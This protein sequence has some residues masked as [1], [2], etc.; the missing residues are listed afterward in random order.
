MKPISKLNFFSLLVER[1]W[2]GGASA[3]SFHSNLISFWLH[4]HY[5]NMKFK[6]SFQCL[7]LKR[8]YNSTCFIDHI[9]LKGYHPSI[10]QHLITVIIILLFFKCWNEIN[11]L[12]CEWREAEQIKRVDGMEVW[13]GQTTNQSIINKNQTFLV[14]CVDWW[15]CCFG[16]R[17]TILFENW[18]FLRH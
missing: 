7:Q 6:F 3:V 10:N 11:S 2:F 18:I 12:F 1:N 4:S 14:C 16:G 8:Y 15:L 9:F 5:A 13:A 17:P